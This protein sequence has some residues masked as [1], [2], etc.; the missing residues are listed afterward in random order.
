MKRVI[1]TVMAVLVVE[2]NEVL[3]QE[4]QV[5]LVKV[6]MEDKVEQAQVHM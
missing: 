1:G 4:A 3:T 5:H 6:M 2:A